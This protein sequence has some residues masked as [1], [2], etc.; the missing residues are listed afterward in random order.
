MDRTRSRF[1][2]YTRIQTRLAAGLDQLDR[3]EQLRKQV[4]FCPSVAMGSSRHRLSSKTFWSD[5]KEQGR[6]ALLIQHEAGVSA[7]GSFC[8]DRLQAQGFLL[9]PFLDRKA[10]LWARLT[11]AVPGRASAQGDLEANDAPGHKA[12]GRSA[13][14]FICSAAS[15]LTSPLEMFD[16]CRQRIV[17]EDFDSL[18]KGFIAIL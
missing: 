17:F 16:Q 8:I 14:K 2:T 9:Q 13:E 1:S 6:N 10:A 18:M 7:D 11:N 4:C 12:A 3:A 5:L 15:T